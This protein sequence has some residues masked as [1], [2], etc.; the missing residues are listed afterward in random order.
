MSRP[1]A[2]RTQFLISGCVLCV[3]HGDSTRRPF[4]ALC[5]FVHGAQGKALLACARLCTDPRKRR[6]LHSRDELRD[7]SLTGLKGGDRFADFSGFCFHWGMQVAGSDVEWTRVEKDGR[8]RGFPVRSQFGCGNE[9][10]DRSADFS[11]KIRM[12]ELADKWH[13]SNERVPHVTHLPSGSHART[14][15]LA[16]LGGMWL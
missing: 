5:R 13:S 16:E 1:R 2:K 9:Q 7:F 14:R 6:G 3:L 11:G 12:T 15:L 10:G 4:S 8:V